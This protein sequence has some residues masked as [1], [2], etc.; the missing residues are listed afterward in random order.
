[1]SKINLYKDS[2]N[3]ML[4]TDAQ[5]YNYKKQCEWAEFQLM[6]T[7]GAMLAIMS[8]SLSHG[9]IDDK[10]DTDMRIVSYASMRTLLTQ[11]RTMDKPIHDASIDA[12]LIQLNA[13]ID[14]LL[15]G[16][17]IALETIGVPSSCVLYADDN[18]SELMRNQYR[19]ITQRTL[20]ACTHT[21]LSNIEH[22]AHQEAKDDSADERNHAIRKCGKAMAE[23]LRLLY[24]AEH[25]ND[26]LNEHMS[27]QAFMSDYSMHDKLVSL[28]AGD[29]IRFD[30]NSLTAYADDSIVSD[31]TNRIDY[32]TVNADKLGLP[33]Q[34]SSETYDYAIDFLYKANLS[35]IQAGESN[36]SNDK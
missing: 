32:L 18:A 20:F 27:F 16:G 17:Q 11:D 35:I 8:G 30:D 34:P 6:N 10:S 24:T 23:S 21:A 2:M 33:L 13:F 36:A 3:N 7:G 29:G 12:T 31:L 25:L 19:F 22:H 28:R 9:L 26:N 1:M 15:K 5:K 14:R 4:L